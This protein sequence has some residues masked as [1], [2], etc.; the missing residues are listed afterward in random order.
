MA[1]PAAS[2]MAHQI[3]PMSIPAM[4]RIR[5]P[6]LLKGDPHPNNAQPPLIRPDPSKGL[7]VQGRWRDP[8]SKA[9]KN[10]RKTQG[11]QVAKAL[12]HQTH[13]LDIYAYRHIRTNQVVYSLTRKLQENKVLKQLLYHG[14]KT[15]PANVRSDMWTPY[16]S[17]HF[18]P[19]P[20]GAL[21]GL[22]AFQKLR[23]LSTQR[24][25][26][27]PEDLIRATQEDIDII[28]AKIGSPVT[29]QEMAIKE[30]LQAK[31]PKLNEILPKKI[32]AQKLMDQ[33]ATSVADMAFVLDW[34][35]SGP[36]PW[37]RVTTVAQNRVLKATELT[38]ANRS[39]LRRIRKEMQ[40]KA[41]EIRRRAA[42]AVEDLPADDRTSLNLTFNTIRQLSLEHHSKIGPSARKLD[43]V[44]GQLI[45]LD[46]LNEYGPQI[47]KVEKVGLLEDWAAQNRA[48]LR[49]ELSPLKERAQIAKAAEQEAIKE[50]FQS[51]DSPSSEMGSLWESVALARENALDTWDTQQRQSKLK[52]SG[53]I[54]AST[55][56][57]A[58][59]TTPSSSPEPDTT[60]IQSQIAALKP[61]W[62]LEPRSV[63]VYWADINDGLF[64]PSWPR[65]VMH[66]SL[67]P[68]GIAKAWRWAPHLDEEGKVIRNAP[69][70]KVARAVGKS[71]HVIGS[72][73]DDGWAESELARVGK[74]PPV[75]VEPPA[76]LLEGEEEV[77]VEYEALG[78]GRVEGRRGRD[79]AV[80]HDENFVVE[81]RSR[82][83]WGRVRG[84]FGR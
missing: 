64:A 27:P 14:K 66:G 13:G 77:E 61:D 8:R 20:A 80:T 60:S 38:E 22:F 71:V 19:T 31:V 44:D 84:L 11:I 68:F 83:L 55:D 50:W 12:R 23:E 74:R 2:S 35:L 65:A 26:S 43:G 81:E 51:N 72:A 21:E 78:E 76:P 41:S 39:R 48:S 7:W 82:G 46:N 69:K 17:I 36:S 45:D 79:A 15:V 29:L 73:A 10:K 56:A 63:K 62:A 6:R 49:T 37:E 24:Q 67:A 4:P 5:P 58:Q 9:V 16:F 25:L 32:R 70:V 53:E 33:K 18:P 52:A 40:K 54:E 34:I 42:L 1:A 75:W 28:K 47:P 57:T 59:S 3:P 30:E